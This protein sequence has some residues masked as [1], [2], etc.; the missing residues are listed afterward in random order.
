VI[1]PS[2]IAIHSE[3]AER[4]ERVVM[5]A[6]RDEVPIAGVPIV[7]PLGDVVDLGVV[8]ANRTPW[9]GADL[10]ALANEPA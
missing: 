10:V 6:H 8:S 9:P 5:A 2:S 3:H 7:L 1:V 4:L